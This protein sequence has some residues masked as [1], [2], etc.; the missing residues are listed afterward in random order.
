MRT[1]QLGKR[2]AAT[3]LA[4]PTAGRRALGAAR[5]AGGTAGP[6]RGA[7]GRS[8]GSI[9]GF[10]HLVWLAPAGEASSP[11]SQREESASSRW[12]RSHGTDV[13]PSSR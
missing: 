7:A 9:H 11:A 1:P 4:A 12:R 10:T 2:R 8:A 5:A 6:G 13:R 3:T